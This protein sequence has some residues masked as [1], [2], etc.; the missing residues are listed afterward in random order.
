[1][2]WSAGARRRR[3]I[4][5]RRKSD[6]ARELRASAAAAEAG[7]LHPDRSPSL[8]AWLE[9]YLREVAAT[10]VRPVTLDGYRQ[11]IRLHITPELGRHRLDQLRPQHVAALYRNLGAALSPSSVRRVHAVLRRAL[12]VAVRW[13]LIVTNP[14]LMVYAPSMTRLEIVPYTA[15]DARALL[16]VTSGDRLEARWLIARTLGLRQARSWGS[17]GSMSTPNAGS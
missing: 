3:T 5:R 12:T 13:G 4:T 6:V 16:D 8:E 9:T 2:G 1:M 15:A 11:L 14:A 17:D 7:Q 10:R